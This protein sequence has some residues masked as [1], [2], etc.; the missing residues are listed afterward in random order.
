[1]NT[2]NASHSAPDAAD[3]GSDRFPFSVPPRINVDS[4]LEQDRL[5]L[6]SE[7]VEVI[8]RHS[9]EAFTDRLE[10]LVDL[11]GRRRRGDPAADAE[12]RHAVATLDEKTMQETVRALHM[13]FDL[14]N[15]A[16]D[17]HRARVLRERER[18]AYPGGMRE[19]VMA[20]I[21]QLRDEGRSP[22]RIGRL[23]SNLFVELVLTA[24]P[25]EAKRRSVRHAIRRIRRD[26]WSL[27]DGDPPPREQHRIVERLRADLACLWETDTLPARRP[28]VIEEARRALLAVRSLWQVVPDIFRT[29][30][31]SL[32]RSYPELD[33]QPATF[34]RFGSWIGGDRDGN[35]FVTTDVTRRT[36]R[37]LRRTAMREHLRECKRLHHR[38]SLSE[39]HHRV[40]DE[41][42]TALTD[43]RQR[44]TGAEDFASRCHESEPYRQWLAVIR[45]RLRQTMRRPAHRGA[46]E[47]A[48]ERADQLI[49][50]LRIIADSLRASNHHRL[51]EGELQDWLDRVAVFGFHLL[52]LDVRD[53]AQRLRTVVAEL[54]RHFKI[55]ENFDSLDEPRRQAALL[56]RFDRRD[57]RGRDLSGLSD[58]A[59][60]T[61][62]LFQLLQTVARVTGG[63]GL[64]A[65]IVSM[66]HEPSD[67]LL[68]VWLSRLGAAMNGLPEGYAP[69][70]VTPLFETIDDLHRG[71][72]MLDEMLRSEAYRRHVDRCGGRQ[73]VMIGYSDS[74]KDGGYLAANWALHRAQARLTA[75]AHRHGVRLTLFH[76]R[77]GALGRGG[78]PAARGILA[79]APGSVNG[80]LRITEQGE[81]LAERYDDP[82][83]A[84]R[85]IEQVLWATLLVSGREANDVPGNW[86]ELLSD[87]ADRSLTAYRALIDEE[88]FVSYFRQATPIDGI[89]G[90]L[91]GSRPSRRR[92]R[93]S[94]SDL[95]A[96]PY[97]FAWIQSRQMLNAFYGL[98]TALE[99]LVERSL[100][101]LREMYE[102]WRFFRGLI[103]NAELALAK[104]EPAIAAEYAALIEDEQRG[105]RI[106]TAIAREY[107]R[108]RR[109]ILA[110]TGRDEMLANIPWLQRSVA[111]RNPYLDLLNFI[112]V[113]TLRR[114]RRSETDS[115]QRGRL[116]R[117]LRVSIQAIAAGMRTTG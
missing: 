114:L 49:S 81:V 1:M 87:A 109:V 83:I 9:G 108:A 102:H 64:G 24:H 78:G 5:S 117:V 29:M 18:E 31:E 103:D 26:L 65:L 85:H 47:G 35:P 34:L 100:P 55:C 89:E 90:L 6:T 61:L 106:W 60:D 54:M 30:R 92:T 21:E 45:F 38:L 51:A 56:Q 3:F 40:S 91:I 80:A 62:E 84:Q 14:N 8:R 70:P 48:Y 71:H 76:G 82:R 25:T 112:Q 96:I 46:A 50:D 19:S 69:M 95:R 37:L 105:R 67:A 99:P 101:T 41:L 22:A 17:R 98:G 59:R 58:D 115:G 104:C 44:W 52:R 73:I 86:R 4:A 53:D 10:E 28:T 11:A 94:L 111:I 39:A 57:I 79:L 77:G 33:V 15:L 12:L 66:T 43:A 113:E 75:T 88:G 72:E 93:Q 13:L 23:L 110:V 74:A 107:D 42:R 2:T 68:M 20:A 63:E 97:T 7:A 32:G 16:E 27:E 36:L 116:E